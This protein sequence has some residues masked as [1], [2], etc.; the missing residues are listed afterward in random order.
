MLASRSSWSSV[1]NVESWFGSLLAYLIAGKCASKTNAL[2]NDFGK[3]VGRTQSLPLRDKLH[4][5]VF[6]NFQNPRSLG[7]KYDR[8]CF[9]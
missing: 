2:C 9:L 6:V 7:K 5:S 8:Y 4:L 3:R 1:H